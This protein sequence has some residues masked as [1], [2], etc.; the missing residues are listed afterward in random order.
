MSPDRE[1]SGSPGLSENVWRQKAVTVWEHAISNKA[2]MFMALLALQYGCQPLLQ[3][4]CIKR[5]EINNI[6]LILVTEAI[7]ILLC[8]AAILSSGAKVY[9]Y[10]G[11]N[12]IKA[13]SSGV[14]VS[15]RV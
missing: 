7:K 3:K 5:N 2:R 4:A 15:F 14:A 13:R 6:S 11:A 9:R 1:V 8:S 10:T 12:V